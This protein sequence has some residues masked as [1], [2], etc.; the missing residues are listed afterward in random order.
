MRP[1]PLWIDPR[2]DRAGPHSDRQR[3]IS[4][5]GD[6]Q[7]ADKAA[8]ND[9][10][11]L[12]GRCADDRSEAAGIVSNDGVGDECGDHE[13][14]EERKD[15]GRDGNGIGRVFVNAAGRSDADILTRG[16]PE[17]HQEEDGDRHPENWVAKLIADLEARDSEKHGASLQAARR[18]VES[19]EK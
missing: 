6:D 14:V 17:T 11:G 19:V 7:P 5:P 13:Y 4:Q 2:H 15:G 9:L 8:D 1:D 3:E 18:K 12:G 16:E 10:V